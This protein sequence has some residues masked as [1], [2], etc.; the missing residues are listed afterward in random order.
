M[1]SALVLST[2]SM[3]KQ[4]WGQTVSSLFLTCSLSPSTCCA[5]KEKGLRAPGGK[6][7]VTLREDMLLAEGFLLVPEEWKT[8]QCGRKW[9]AGSPSRGQA[10]G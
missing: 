1:N 10:H 8:G 4:G 7:A 2:F 9:E 6:G 3:N 5:D